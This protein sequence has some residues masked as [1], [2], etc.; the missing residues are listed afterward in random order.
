MIEIKNLDRLWRRFRKAERHFFDKGLML[1]VGFF[2]VTSIE[3]RTARGVGAD[4]ERFAPYSPR[5]KLFREK[6]GHVGDIV[7]LQYTGSMLSS[8]T[9]DADEDKAHVYFMNTVDEFGMSNPAKAFFIHEDQDR[10][11]FAISVDEQDQIV[12]MVQQHF[13]DLIFE[14]A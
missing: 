4:G 11:F 7:N 3:L 2:I 13:Q 12:K 9:Q 14:E 10:K 5:Y 8:M 6:K 1:E